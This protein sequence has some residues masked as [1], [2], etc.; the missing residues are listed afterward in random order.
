MIISLLKNYLKFFVFSAFIM[1]IVLLLKIV[2]P[3]L[4]HERI[5]EILSFI[6][7]LSFLIHLLNSFLLRNFQENFFQI[8]VFA[9]I[10]RFIASLVFI[11]WQVWPAMENIIL[12]I[13]NFFVLFLFYLVFD[14]YTIISNLRRNSK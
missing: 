11:A 2:T 4:T 6:A 1:G 7:L 9:M 8:T 14:M 12:F 3:E 10:L 13:A 5:W